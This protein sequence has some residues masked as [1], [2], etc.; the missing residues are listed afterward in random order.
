M[1][2]HFFFNK[3]NVNIFFTKRRVHPVKKQA[4][5]KCISMLLPPN[6]FLS[7]CPYIPV[8]IKITKYYLKLN[9]K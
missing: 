1:Q 3:K 6:S 8:S 9:L 2:V 4:G 5:K 7:A